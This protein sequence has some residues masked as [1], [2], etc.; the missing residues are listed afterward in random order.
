MSL[1][2]VQV[3]ARCL[4]QLI[5]QAPATLGVTVPIDP[6][7]PWTR[8][9]IYA[10]AMLAAATELAE[11]VAAE[12]AAGRLQNAGRLARHLFEF[13]IEMSWVLDN[14]AVRLPTRYAE[15]ARSTFERMNP[16]V[17]DRL[18]TPD[19]DPGR[20]Q[21]VALLASERARLGRSGNASVLP[22]RE[23]MA[24]DL[25]RLEEFKAVYPSMSWTS[26]PGLSSAG[27]HVELDG[28]RVRFVAR[29]NPVHAVF[30]MGPLCRATASFATCIELADAALRRPTVVDVR[31]AREL[32]G[33]TCASW[34]EAL[35]APVARH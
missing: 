10:G 12:V 5:S 7:P 24:D 23:T 29:P 3:A 19:M 35:R 17:L 9:E 25:G 8:P 28:D 2:E 26:H 22:A 13:D 20:E 11:G 27:R 4:D 32:T 30:Y 14:P 16:A 33:A 18:L 15:E 31:D 1:G 21:L 6:Q 34:E